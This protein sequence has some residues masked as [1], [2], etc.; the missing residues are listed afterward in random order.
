MTKLF[1]FNFGWNVNAAA[2]AGKYTH[3]GHHQ[4]WLIDKLYLIL[5]D[6]MPEA[7][8]S[9]MGQMVNWQCTDIEKY[10]QSQII[11]YHSSSFNI[12]NF[13]IKLLKRNKKPIT[14]ATP[15]ISPLTSKVDIN[16]ISMHAELIVKG[17]FE[18]IFELTGVRTTP[19]ILKDFSSRQFS[20]GV[21]KLLT[22]T[23]GSF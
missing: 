11:Q 17:D 21:A 5:W 13:Q 22:D 9:T 4:L 2:K 7:K 1:L 15:A 16:K 10:L 20:A 3:P 12:E 18:K 8:L 23:A 14:T 19:Q 6:W